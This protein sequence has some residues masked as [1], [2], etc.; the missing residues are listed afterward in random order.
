MLSKDRLRLGVCVTVAVALHL[1]LFFGTYIPGIP[2]AP[3]V[4]DAV[5]TTL[6]SPAPRPE[7]EVAP[8]VAALDAPAEPEPP[9]ASPPPEAAPIAPPQQIAT[10]TPPVSPFAGRNVA[11]LARAVAATAT[12]TNEH[13]PSRVRRLGRVAPP[14]GTDFAYYLASWRRKVERVGQLNYPREARA[15]GIVGSLRLLVTITPDGALDDVRV[16]ETSGHALL[17]DA[18]L[19]IVR[20]AAPY[21]PFPPTMRATTDVLEIERTW[22]FLNSR[23]SS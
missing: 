3:A 17:D 6:P 5:L 16:L 14:P 13:A 12:P 7:A 20:L 2:T 15:Q 10:P 11:A 22:R 9:A 1:A 21:A 23:L 19:R 8:P 4:I 18:A